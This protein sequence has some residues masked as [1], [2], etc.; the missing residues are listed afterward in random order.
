[1]R[2]L[3]DGPVSMSPTL[4]AKVS[5][6]YARLDEALQGG[7][8]E[9][10]SIV[11]MAAAND[12]NP[13]LLRKFLEVNKEESLLVCRSLS[14]VETV[15]GEKLDNVKSIVCS[16]KPISPARNILP[17]KSIDNLTDLNLQMSEAVGSIRPKRIVLDILSDVLLRHKALQTR[18]WLTELLERLRSK[19]ITVLAV[20]NPHMHSDEEVQAVV[21]L[22]DGNIE[23]IE[24]EGE[25]SLRVNWMHGIEVAEKELSLTDLTLGYAPID[26]LTIPAV[27]FREPR[28]LTPLVNRKNELSKLEAALHEAVD[29]KS[30]VVGIH[31]E[32]GVGKTRLMRELATYAQSTRATVLAGRGSE[33]SIPYTPWVEVTREYIS[34]APAEALRRMLGSHVSDFA[35]LVPDITAKVGTVPPSKPLGE[36]QD[37]IRLF[38]SITHFLIS[39]SK[40]SPLLIL[41]DDLQW[42][43]Q[44]SL[45]LLEYFVRSTG[46]L[47]VL[48]VCTY[49]T[50]D[51]GPDTPLHKMLTKLNRDRLL[52]ALPVKNLGEQD[53][54]RLIE[55]VFGEKQTSIDFADLIQKTTGGNP[56]FVEEVLRSLVEDGTIFRTEKGWDRKPIQEITVPESVKSTLTS[57]LSKLES[58]TL[59]TLIWASVMGPEFDFEVLL[60]VSQATEDQLVQRLETAISQGLIVEVPRERSKFRFSD[61]R[62]REML[63]DDLIQIKRA[64][65][66]LKIAEAMEKLYSKKLDRHV[67]AIANHFSEGGDT[68]RCV[69]YSVAAGD[70][71]KSVHVYE[72]AIRDY[73]RA[74]ELLDLEGGKEEE[75]T[76]LLEKLGAC[77]A[78]AG[79]LRNSRQSYERALSIF[80]RKGDHKA[81]A[82][83]CREIAEAVNAV[84]LETGVEEAATI[85]RRGLNYLEG[86]PDSDE[87]ASTYSSLAFSL[88]I[89]DQFDEA[90]MWAEKALEVGK[91]TNN[92]RAVAE[93]LSIQGSYLTD[94]G[95]IDEGL[96]L[97]QQAY[98]LALRHGDDLVARI[99]AFNLSIYAYPRDMAKAREWALKS[100]ELA[101]N[102]NIMISEARGWYW[103][104]ILDWLR[105]E[106]T[107]AH[108]QLQKAS[109]IME[110]VGIGDPLSK[111]ELEAWKGWFA[112][113]RGDL[114]EAERIL[115]EANRLAEKVPKIT[116][117]VTTN[118]A[119]GL[120]MLEA[121]KEKE[122]RE[123]FEKSVDAFKNWEFTTEPLLHIETLL[124]LTSLYSRNRELEKAGKTAKWALRLAEQLRSEAGL[125]MAW[126]AKA[127]LLY[128]GGGKKEAEEAFTKCI[129]LWKKAGWPYYYAKALAAYSEAIAQGNPEE[130]KKRLGEATETFRKL[131]A[132]R[133]LLRAEGRLSLK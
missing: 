125:A 40:E 11:L 86:E 7:F 42:A 43:D 103:V 127:N 5:T 68:E 2:N 15:V 65:Y 39:V 90:N 29:G 76:S 58:E 53:T 51:A 16:D 101:H 120:L 82:R 96:P 47:R 4:R 121:G 60:E 27:A 37:R 61:N 95:K 23:L 1:M 33:D 93:A 56:F 31:G 126:Q 59:G 14:R 50:E 80:E 130:S 77:Y 67:E 107:S 114:E 102:G 70:F 12:E 44:A 91:K 87:A 48:V 97:W 109:G 75:M 71:N 35:R 105:G 57:R 79:Q 72:P 123:H 116:L 73:R 32:A 133:D 18:K 25:K 128:A 19:N 34:Q 85:L 63:L 41:L 49:R 3:T 22:F 20:V 131:G 66:H 28:W 92:F 124:H 54:G 115:Q 9:G 110:R 122:A 98:E 88:A 89:M 24:G 26:E 104:S 69:K 113:G 119:L 74:V 21:G 38:E 118:L 84:K 55:Q 83:T 46:N 8:M 81:C 78:F 132:K 129:E 13:L 94:S 36:Q 64:R 52:E 10:S 6:G 111:V 30:S 108:E 99:C 17:G 117:I 106:W 112:L 100:I 45:D 62:I